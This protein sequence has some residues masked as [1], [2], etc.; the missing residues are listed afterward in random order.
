MPTDFASIQPLEQKATQLESAANTNA[1][2]GMTLS[3]KL[4]TAV[5]ERF[6]NN[7]ISQQREGAL[8]T[9]LQAPDQARQV[10][11]DKVNSGTI[12]S[13]TQQQS[14][15][16]GVR[17]NAT[18]PLVSLND[19]LKST[20]GNISDIVGAGT[21]AFNAQTANLQGQA[22]LARSS[23]NTAFDRLMKQAQ[24][25][26]EQ[27]KLQLEKQKSGKGSNF[28]QQI[29]A[30]A[31][32]GGGA[33]SGMPT[34][35]KPTATPSDDMQ[36]RVTGQIH[37]PSGQWIF[38]REIGD[39]QPSD[40]PEGKYDIGT[41]AVDDATG[42]AWEYTKNGWTSS[43]GG[44]GGKDLKSLLTPDVLLGGLLSGDLSSGDFT[45]LQSLG[46]L[47]K[48]PTAT[49]QMAANNAQSGL[50]A[51]QTAKELIS[52][53]SGIIGTSKIPLLGGLGKAGTYKTAVKEVADVFTRLRTGAALNNQEIDFYGGQ[54]PQVTDSPETIQY[55]LNLFGNLFNDVA[56]RGGV[57]N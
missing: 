29:L 49:Q 35:G 52:N 53:D 48:P 34:E 42:T 16:S 27:Q 38:N 20:F 47:N 19:L 12:L 39:W 37:S 3:D 44:G 40:I 21:N 33:G 23:A 36:A 51:L 17:A 56:N 54:L 46:V 22:Q 26:I 24:L 4:R 25:D 41:K 43:G 15:M 55:K 18:V 7:P 57:A 9:F 10:V 2:A 1:A 6:A 13:P 31:G 14:I 8:S 11:A 5:N 50:R 32:K 45:A 28:L 30:M